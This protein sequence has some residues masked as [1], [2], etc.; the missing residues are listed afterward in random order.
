MS[1]QPHI[2][3]LHQSMGP[4]FQDMPNGE[5]TYTPPDALPNQA[6]VLKKKNVEMPP[7]KLPPV[8]TG[9]Q[10]RAPWH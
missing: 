3:Q 8:V 9:P 5:K 1:Y 6:P 4:L 10:V 7:K 2:S